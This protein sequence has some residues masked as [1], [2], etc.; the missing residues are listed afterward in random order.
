LAVKSLILYNIQVG[1]YIYAIYNKDAN[2]FYI[3]QTIDL[4]KRIDQHNNHDLGGYTS[5]FAGEWV[6][7]YQESIA[8]RQ[9]ALKR[10]KQLKSFRGREYIKT[11]IPG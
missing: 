7:I 2:R 6:L 1:Y 3:G 4:S 8:T 10:E 9:Q 5:R 11:F